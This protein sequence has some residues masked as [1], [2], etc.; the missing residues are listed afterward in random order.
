MR[1]CEAGP[2]AYVVKRRDAAEDVASEDLS[3][4][5][6]QRVPVAGEHAARL[7]EDE[8]PVRGPVHREEIGGRA[9]DLAARAAAGGAAQGPQGAD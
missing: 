4:D 5:D 7:G 3:A 1:P 9:P 2:V 6:P 8:A